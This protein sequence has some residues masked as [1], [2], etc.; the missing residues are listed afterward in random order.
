MFRTGLFVSGGLYIIG[1]FSWWYFSA[2]NETQELARTYVG[3]GISWYLIAFGGVLNVIGSMLSF[4]NPDER[5]KKASAK[6]RRRQRQSTNLAIVHA[7][8]TS[9]MTKDSEYN[10]SQLSI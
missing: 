1:S 7:A 3:V 2:C 9:L 5:L 4:K 8:T 6:R 10:N